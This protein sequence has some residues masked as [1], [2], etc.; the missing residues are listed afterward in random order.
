M[1]SE[2]GVKHTKNLM[3]FFHGGVWLWGNYH[4]SNNLAMNFAGGAKTAATC[5][6]V[7]EETETIS[8][9]EIK[10][11]FLIFDVEGVDTA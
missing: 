9:L 8:P 1:S 10:Y 5:D 7:L 4:Y 6:D 11:A 3:Q 2:F